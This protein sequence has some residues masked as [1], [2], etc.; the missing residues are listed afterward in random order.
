LKKRTTGFYARYD[1]SEQ[2]LCAE[3]LARYVKYRYRYTAWFAPELSG[4]HKGFLY[5][6]ENHLLI[7]PG[8]TPRV[9]EVLKSCD[10][11]FFFEPNREIFDGLPKNAVTALV[12]PPEPRSRDITDFGRRCTYTLTSS[13]EEQHRLLPPKLKNLLFWPFDPVILRV[14]KPEGKDT[15]EP[16]RLFFPAFGFSLPLRTL[17]GQ[18]ASIL[19]ACRPELQTVIGFYNTKVT[20]VPGTDSRTDDWRMLRYLRSSDVVVDLNPATVCPLFAALTGGCRI[21][22]I[23]FDLPPGNDPVNRNHSRFLSPP[24]RKDSFDPETVA[25]QIL[26][27]LEAGLPSGE[28]QDADLRSGKDDGGIWKQRYPAFLKATNTVLGIRSL[29]GSKDVPPF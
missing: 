2:T 22:R 7:W 14:E 19:K 5:N 16:F 28:E 1:A 17:T 4:R 18:V 10:T 26:A 29:S 27:L 15:K 24:A 3:F 23:G 13:S 8:K 11:F 20:P 6:R 12:L 21:P 9:R 25:E